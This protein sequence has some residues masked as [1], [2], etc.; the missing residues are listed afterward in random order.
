MIHYPV[1]YRIAAWMVQNLFMAAIELLRTFKFVWLTSNLLITW[2]RL[3]L[4]RVQSHS[5]CLTMSLCRVCWFDLQTEKITMPIICRQGFVWRIYHLLSCLHTLSYHCE[6]DEANLLENDNM[7]DDYLRVTQTAKK[8]LKHFKYKSMLWNLDKVFVSNES[9]MMDDRGR[10]ILKK[11]C[12]GFKL[13]VFRMRIRKLRLSSY[14]CKGLRL[15]I[16]QLWRHARDWFEV[17][18][19][20]PCT[21]DAK[22][23]GMS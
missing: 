18:G 6:R 19:R 12:W 23:E 11:Y 9:A 4:Y 21:W 17:W 5:E 1:K 7:W 10:R 22:D 14:G 2:F 13:T 8:L 3:R 16:L 15:K 20:K